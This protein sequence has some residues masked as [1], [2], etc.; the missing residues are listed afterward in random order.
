VYAGGF[1]PATEDQEADAGCIC[2]MAHSMQH[3]GVEEGGWGSEGEGEEGGSQGDDQ[4][5]EG[6]TGVNISEISDE[7][8][9]GSTSE[10]EDEGE[11]VEATDGT[12]S[13]SD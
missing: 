12:D 8:S 13:Q 11:L 1:V 4:V 9:A 2:D 10:E 3:F 5:E 7:H 6:A